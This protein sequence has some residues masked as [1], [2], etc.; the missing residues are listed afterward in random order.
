MFKTIV[1][2]AFGFLFISCAVVQPNALKA[3]QKAFEEEDIYILYALYAKESKDFKSAAKL[4]DTLYKKSSK[5]EYLY[6]TLEN[7]LLAK[8]YEEI[9]TKTEILPL[10]LH[11]DVKIVRFKIVALYELERLEEAQ[12][13][14]VALA[15]QTQSS[16]DYLLVGDVLIKSKQYD[17]ALRYLDSA[18]AKEYDE[19]ILDKMAIILYVNLKRGKDAMAHL[20][21]HSRVHGISKLI[22]SRLLG[23]YSD[24]NNIEGLLATYKRLYTLEKEQEIAK[25]IAQ[26][27][28][29]KRDY[30]RL[31]AFLEESKSDN[32]LLLQ[33]YS[34]AK[35]YAKAYP[36]AEKLYETT[37]EIEYLGQSAIYEYENAPSKKEKQLLQ[38]VVKK[39]QRVVADE[40]DP[41]FLNYLGYLLIDHS[42]DV[43]QGDR[44][45]V[46]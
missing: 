36:L 29:Y 31:I 2:I 23:F 26:I 1:L 15:K 32:A 45:S 8:E 10:E 13:L 21:T 34:S 12:N 35:N 14:A 42:I 33:L 43:K 4:F 27:Y 11:E 44:K 17:L 6:Q 19:K 25:K 46:V 3:N 22:A 38:R 30:L 28:A 40:S 37:G 9:V 5:R 24:Q 41:T 20:E 39:L 18:Y 7:Q 16:D